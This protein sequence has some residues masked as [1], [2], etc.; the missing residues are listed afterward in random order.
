AARDAVRAE[1]AAGVRRA[2]QGAADQVVAE[3]GQTTGIHPDRKAAD[4][5]KQQPGAGGGGVAEA[6]RGAGERVGAGEGTE[7][8]AE[9]GGSEE[10]R[11]R[12]ARSESQKEDEEGGSG[13]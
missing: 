6:G 5:G 13:D 11:R 2:A 4:D 8:A 3:E 10:E 12:S 7:A 1:D 9:Q